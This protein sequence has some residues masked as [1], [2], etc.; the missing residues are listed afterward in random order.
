M[1][2]MAIEKKGPHES[3]NKERSKLKEIPFGSPT[4]Q[5]FTDGAFEVRLSNGLAA[6]KLPKLGGNAEVTLPNITR[7][8][9]HQVREVTKTIQ[10][11]SANPETG[12]SYREARERLL[13]EV[14][15]TYVDYFRTN[16]M[17]FAPAEKVEEKAGEMLEGDLDRIS[18]KY[19]EEI[20]LQRERGSIIADP[21]ERLISYVQEVAPDSPAKLVISDV[22]AQEQIAVKLGDTIF[23]YKKNEDP[24]VDALI[25]NRA[26]IEERIR[27]RTHE[28]ET[29]AEYGAAF[30]EFVGLTMLARRKIRQ[31]L[32]K[33]TSDQEVN[34]RYGAW[35]TDAITDSSQ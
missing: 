4:W 27:Q 33:N 31:E 30:I 12:D 16:L 13:G 24:E 35:L 3:F 25:Q 18:G 19:T 8:K 20:L 34:R 21:K 23:S 32:P 14:V 10:E 2:H 6:E 11:R 7:Y 29:A 9:E 5:A 1:S 22:F 17:M 15:P 26:E 28:S